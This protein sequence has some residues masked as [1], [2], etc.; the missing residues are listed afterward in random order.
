[1]HVGKN[2][3]AKF[4]PADGHK[5]SPSYEIGKGRAFDCKARRASCVNGVSANNERTI[6][7]AAIVNGWLE[8]AYSFTE[9]SVRRMRCR[10]WVR[11]HREKSGGLT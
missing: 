11:M 5:A 10:E 4:A 9:Q 8:C 1:V 6:L 2:K 3:K 7:P